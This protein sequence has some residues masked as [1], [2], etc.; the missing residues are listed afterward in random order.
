[1]IPCILH[2][3]EHLLVVDKP[4]GLNTHAPA[5]FA[6]EGL[7]DWLRHREPCWADLAIL[8]R[9][10]KDTSGV[11]VFGKTAAANRALTQQ[12]TAH[13][14]EKTYLLL[15]DRP[16]RRDAFT[17]KSALVRVGEKYT[18]TRTGGEPAETHFR[19]RR[20]EGDCTLVEA[21]PRTGRTH[22]I[23]VHAAESGMPILGDTLYGGTPAA[24][25][26]LHAAEVAFQ[27]PANGADCRFA[28]PAPFAAAGLPTATNLD[29]MLARRRA[30]VAPTQ[31]DAFRLVHGASDGWPG[32]YVE[33]LGDFL[34]SQSAALLSPEQLKTLRDLLAVTG[35]RGAYHKRLDRQVR[36]A[37]PDQVAPQPVLGDPAPDRFVVREN[38]LRF[39]LSFQE[40]YSVGLFLDQ[41]DN[42]RRFLTGH[43]A[44][45]FPLRSAERET[46]GA[47]LLNTFAYT[48]GFSVAAA[49]AGWRTTSLDLSRKYLDWGR[50]NF[51]LNGLEPGA[52][53]FIFGDTFEWLRRL[54][55]K[56]RRFDAV[57][58]DPPTFSQSKAG[59]VF[60]AERD[61]GALVRTAL[62]VLAPDGVLF[63]S[64][65]AAGWPAEE[66]VAAVESAVRA[67]GRTIRAE[68]FFPQPPDFPVSRVEPGY[69]KTLWLRVA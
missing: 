32:W 68:H 34:Y 7:Y 3:D 43:V 62:A 18:G 44:A 66:F 9:L 49:R 67:A 56:G 35:T 38:G 50:R 47:A 6:G 10:D 2:E 64:T 36:R 60:R 69:L 25:V 53:D 45:G 51:E 29:V 30:L 11:M 57:V 20:R 65:N 46:G 26:H 55:K 48:C 58:L 33:R 41:R 24:R 12:F 28:A 16:V 63:A 8:H 1:M 40:G 23:R 13:T 22:Q 4:A 17:V 19:V 14:V 5:P 59:G 42:R 52:H 15:T 31:T 39:E 37:A 61:Y 21:S 27:H 54:A